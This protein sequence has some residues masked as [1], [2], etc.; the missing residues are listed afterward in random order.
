MFLQNNPFGVLLYITSYYSYYFSI[1][2]ITN[3]IILEGEYRDDGKQVTVQMNNVIMAT[4]NRAVIKIE[5][6]G[7]N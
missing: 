2:S 5:F 3:F 7:V 1:I 4:E 6:V